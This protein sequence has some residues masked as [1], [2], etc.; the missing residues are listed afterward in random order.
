MGIISGIAVKVI[1]PKD[2]KNI[3]SASKCKEVKVRL[4]QKHN[5]EVDKTLE[6][7]YSLLT[8]KHSFS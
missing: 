6:S 5:S 8:Y 7:F 3:L 2:Q 4:T 1:R